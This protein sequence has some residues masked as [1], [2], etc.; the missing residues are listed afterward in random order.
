MLAIR[1]GGIRASVSR[2]THRTI[3]IIIKFE[4]RIWESHYSPLSLARPLDQ[5][6]NYFVRCAANEYIGVMEKSTYNVWRG[7]RG[8]RERSGG[9]QRLLSSQ[10]KCYF[11]Y[12]N[13][14]CIMIR[15]AILAI[16]FNRN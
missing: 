9:K 16:F 1:C 3:I 12:F 6:Y 8:R 14:N 13:R 15:I 5:R 4:T 11:I 10:N 2:I 7:R